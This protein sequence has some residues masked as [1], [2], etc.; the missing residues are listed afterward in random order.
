M[1][2]PT[3]DPQAQKLL[4]AG[5]AAGL[6]PVYTLSTEEAR[7]RMRAGFISD[8]PYEPVDS[9]ENVVIPGPCGGIPVRIY[10][11]RAGTVPVIVFFH[12]GG[13]VLNDLDTHERVC[14]RLSNAVDAAVVSVDYRRAPEAPY[15]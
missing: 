2:T 11:P 3:L 1:T 13:W 12:G 4:D 7:G 14:R 5:A 10:R 9:V 15:P 8:A 6:P